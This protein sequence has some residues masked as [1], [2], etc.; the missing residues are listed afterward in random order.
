MYKYS[1]SFGTG[2]NFNAILVE[3]DPG[4]LT[5]PDVVEAIYNMEIEMREAI[6]DVFP[7]I[8]D[9]RLEKSVYS[10]VD[11][12][13]ELTGLVNRSVILKKLD[14]F[15]NV[16]EV[17]YDM[18]AEN[19]IVDEEY[20]KTLILVAIPIGS[21]V[22]KITQV[23][24][25]INEIAAR[26]VLPYNGKVSHLTGQDA[27]VITVNNE[28][29]EQQIRSMVIA[30]IL[31][32]A[33]LIIIFNS[34]KYGFLTMTPVIFVLMWEPGFLVS[35]DIPLSLATISIASIMIGVGI[36]YGVH[37]THRF[38]EERAN[39]LSNRDAIKISIE[40]TGSSLVEAALTTIAGISAIYIA[41]TPALNQFVTVVIL[42][43][44]L[45]CIAAALIL[46]VFYD[47]KFV[48]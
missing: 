8:D 22:E 29:T 15:L 10:V 48:K 41:N 17:I 21:Q 36:D 45:S 28:L 20:S 25:N 7:T 35:L 46:P 40:R 42:M 12:I 34:S 38:R 32:L 11:E 19:G 2:S 43:T 5:D 27:V 16:Q 6:R 44:A 39:G 9:D 13:K 14:E 26:T 4:G 3:M 30:L 18:I 24:D 33:A 31:V 37:I 1:E 47:S 23:I